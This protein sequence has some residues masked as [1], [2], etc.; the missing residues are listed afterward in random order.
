MAD[1]P[2]RCRLITPEARVFDASASYASVPM[3]DG[4]VGVMANTGAMVGKLGAGELRVEFVDRY[5]Q[6]V[7]LEESGN[8][9][10]F[11][12][13]GFMQNV[14]NVLTILASTCK[15]VNELN[16]EE[17]QAELAEAK[18]RKS[19]KSEEMDRITEQRNALRVKSAL[20]RAPGSR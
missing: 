2:F 11:I 14:N 5:E 3:H 10:F 12:A 1:K 15:P 17:A 16:A 18:S 9:R 8:K 20:A 13:G 4:K 19:L 6:G 7:K